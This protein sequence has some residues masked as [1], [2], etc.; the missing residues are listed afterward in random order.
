LKRSSAPRRPHPSSKAVGP[1]LIVW[2]VTIAA[3]GWAEIAREPAIL[4]AFNPAHGA[5]FLSR[6][7]LREA[8]LIL[9]ALILVV[10]GGEAI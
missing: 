3:L 8:L 2:F 7:G 5:A 10:A 1:L 9:S 6:S 4:A